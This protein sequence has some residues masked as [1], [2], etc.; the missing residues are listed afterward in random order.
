MKLGSTLLAALAIGAAPQERLETSRHPWMKHAPGTTVA[1]TFTS[2]VGALKQE[3]RITHVLKSTGDEGYTVEVKIAQLGTEQTL[4]E[5]DAVP[6]RA[7]REK[8]TLA[9]RELDCTVWESKG[10]RGPAAATGKFWLAEGIAMPVRVV[11]RVEGQEEYDLS[12]TSL[13]EKLSAAGKEYACVKLEG[14]TKGPLGE[15]ETEL[16]V[17]D[18]VPGGAVKMVAR[19]K[20]QGNAA[21][22]IL[23]LAGVS[24]KK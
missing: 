20:V 24:E 4:E 17:S 8:L 13:E 1:Y 11:S 2:E 18:R 22:T 9:G 5:K 14:K 15:A 10:S 3:G 16:W 6:V 21:T 12:A 23:E 19:A 7:G